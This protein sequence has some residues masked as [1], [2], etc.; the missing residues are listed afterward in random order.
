VTDKPTATD[1]D[2][3]TDQAPQWRVDGAAAP[4]GEQGLSDTVVRI[5][6]IRDDSPPPRPRGPLPRTD[7]FTS[8][9]TAAPAPVLPAEVEP[10]APVPT[11][12]PPGS[13]APPVEPVAAAAAASVAAAATE[14]PSVRPAAPRPKSRRTRKARLRLSRLDPWSVMKT[15]FLFSIAFG[16]MLWVGTY[17]TWTVVQGSGLFESLNEQIQNIFA[18]PNDTTPFRIED[19]ISTNKVLGVA[20]LFAVINVVLMTA[21]GTLFAFLYNLSANILGGLELTLAED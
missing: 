17:V 9:A 2:A 19:Y 15:V 21:I 11:P 6:P 12:V 18:S 14:P 4:E 13:W 7:I 8:A 5:P 1:A 3:G 20:A 10:T 16:I